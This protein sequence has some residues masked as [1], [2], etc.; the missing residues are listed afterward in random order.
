[1]RGEGVNLEG[2]RTVRDNYLPNRRVKIPGKEVWFIERERYFAFIAEHEVIL[3][4]RKGYPVQVKRF[5][6]AVKATTV[7]PDRKD[8]QLDRQIPTSVWEGYLK[9]H[10]FYKTDFIRVG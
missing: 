3:I 10:G 6:D 8:V 1:M 2:L 4:P 9:E 7:S 5:T